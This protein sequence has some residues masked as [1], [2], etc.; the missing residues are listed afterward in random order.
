M[1]VVTHELYCAV[2]A[3]VGWHDSDDV[4]EGHTAPELIQSGVMKRFASRCQIRK[5]LWATIREYE[6]L[7]VLDGQTR[8]H[9]NLR[10]Y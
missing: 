2:C 3:Q 8:V 4:D 6:P 10:L 7:D 5:R 9:L 1:M